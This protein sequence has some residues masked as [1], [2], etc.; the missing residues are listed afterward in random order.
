[1]FEGHLRVWGWA[2]YTGARRAVPRWAARE[3][4]GRR[5]QDELHT[6]DSETKNKTSPGGGDVHDHILAPYLEICV[7]SSVDSRLEET[8]NKGK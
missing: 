3:L 7:S 8:K 6:L 4:I 1:M 2:A 5:D